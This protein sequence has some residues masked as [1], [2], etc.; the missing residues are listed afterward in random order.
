[1]SPSSESICSPSNKA[2]VDI[3]NYRR[4]VDSIIRAYISSELNNPMDEEF[5]E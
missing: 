2:S 3:H 1:V 5:D 4:F